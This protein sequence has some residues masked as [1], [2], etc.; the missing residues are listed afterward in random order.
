L[1]LL[2]T[3]QHFR[4]ELDGTGKFLLGGCFCLCGPSCFGPS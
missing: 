4:R 3:G 2:D 1:R